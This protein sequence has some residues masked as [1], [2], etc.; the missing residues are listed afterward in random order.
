MGLEKIKGVDE[1]KWRLI[2]RA[3]PRHRGSEFSRPSMAVWYRSPVVIRGGRKNFRLCSGKLRSGSEKF[4]GEGAE[5]I[6]EDNRDSF[7]D[8]DSPAEE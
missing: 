8:D 3:A 2:F 4:A 7:D 1:K 6:G 5:E